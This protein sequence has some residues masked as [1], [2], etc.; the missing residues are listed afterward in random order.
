MLV[1]ATS[2]CMSS[3]AG[4]FT[5]TPPRDV[6]VAVGV[7]DEQVDAVAATIDAVARDHRMT[8]RLPPPE[9]VQRRLERLYG[10]QLVVWYSRVEPGPGKR[11]VMLSFN[12]P[13][14]LSFVEVV[15]RDLGHSE[16][17]DFVRRLRGGVERG[18]RA[19][20]PGFT[21]DFQSAEVDATFAP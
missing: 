19:A 17:S 4:V 2:S 14:D 12:L 10:D 21:L 11:A 7:S 13:N 15:I 3:Y 20:L 5:A 16:A 6:G 9:E 1:V 18:L 8:R